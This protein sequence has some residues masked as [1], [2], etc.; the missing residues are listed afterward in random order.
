[1]CRGQWL[2]KAFTVP[3]GSARVLSPRYRCV[4]IFVGA[5]KVAVCNAW[6]RP[7]VEASVVEHRETSRAL[8]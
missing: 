6:I 4:T 7:P 8:I 5:L 1:M 3:R 2:N